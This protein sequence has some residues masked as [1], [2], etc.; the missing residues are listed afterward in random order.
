MRIA[1]AKAKGTVYKGRIPTLNA[2]K[3]CSVAGESSNGS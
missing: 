2:E 1:L 3:G